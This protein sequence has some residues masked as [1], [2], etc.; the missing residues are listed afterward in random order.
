SPAQWEWDLVRTVL[1][2][3]EKRAHEE[4]K[5]NRTMLRM[6]VAESDLDA[7]SSIYQRIAADSNRLL[8]IQLALAQRPSRV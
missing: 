2:I 1:R 8:Q 7:I 5:Q 3:R 4:E 6:A